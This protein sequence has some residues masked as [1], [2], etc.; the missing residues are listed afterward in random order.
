M[1]KFMVPM[2]SPQER[3]NTLEALFERLIPKTA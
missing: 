3:F 1:F 2:E